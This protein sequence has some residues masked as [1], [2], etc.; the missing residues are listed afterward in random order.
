MEAAR[1][2]AQRTPWHLVC[3][4]A[5]VDSARPASYWPID[6]CLTGFHREATGAR[7]SRAT[8]SARSVRTT[9]VDATKTVAVRRESTKPRLHALSRQTHV[10]TTH[11]AIMSR[12]RRRALELR[13]R[14]RAGSAL[15]IR[16][17][18]G[19]SGRDVRHRS[20]RARL[21]ALWRRRENEIDTSY[22]SMT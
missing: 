21:C 18:R 1:R 6:D 19:R 5:P 10:V 11:G 3:C 22:G 8:T 17:Y 15:R 12:G 4:I 7:R 16:R 9:A 2:N 13:S 14:C 20:P